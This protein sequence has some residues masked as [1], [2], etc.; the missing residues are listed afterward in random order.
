M[1][2][3]STIV[4]HEVKRGKAPTAAE[5]KQFEAL[6]ADGNGTI[7]KAEFDTYVTT[8]DAVTSAPEP[9]NQHT[10]PSR[11]PKPTHQPLQDN[12]GQC[13]FRTCRK[14]QTDPWRTVMA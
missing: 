9:R 1:T 5:L 3:L 10:P 4:R 7:E 8:L 14:V 13:A 2:E 6:D 11:S 12:P